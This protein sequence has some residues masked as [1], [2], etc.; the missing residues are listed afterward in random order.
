MEIITQ[1]GMVIGFGYAGELAARF[2]PVRLPAG[3]LGII[4]VFISL[5]FHITKPRQFGKTADFISAHMGFFFLP[6]AVSVLQNY[7]AIAPV[8][9]QFIAICIISTLITFAVS[10]SAVRI[11]RIAMGRSENPSE[12]PPAGTG[13]AGRAGK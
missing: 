6:L 12:N 11:L 1:L 5:S 7:Q 13:K 8:L 10:Y 4:F 9:F 3:V 2:L